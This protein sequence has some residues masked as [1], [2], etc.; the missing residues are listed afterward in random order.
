[1]IPY[2]W[3][4]AKGL[5]QYTHGGTVRKMSDFMK[6]S[7]SGDILDDDAMADMIQALAAS[8]TP[9][10]DRKAKPKAIKP[11]KTYDENEMVEHAQNL[12]KAEQSR[13]KRRKRA[14]LLTLEDTPAPRDNQLEELKK[15]VVE[16]QGLRTRDTTDPDFRDMVKTI[17]RE[18]RLEA[19][20]QLSLPSPAA[21][22]YAPA[23]YS[24]QPPQHSRRQMHPATHQPHYAA[25]PH[26]QQL[27]HAPPPLPPQQNHHYAQSNCYPSPMRYFSD[28]SP[29]HYGGHSTSPSLPHPTEYRVPATICHSRPA[30]IGHTHHDP[31]G[32]SHQ[33]YPSHPAPHTRHEYYPRDYY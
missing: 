9:K 1:M 14:E 22:A 30:H 17:S 15:Q 16:L 19:E 8:S 32:Y 5:H 7:H 13:K 6:F 12:N 10:P 31:G 3:S 33:G 21:H 18:E 2:L 20:Q 28:G 23:G 26:Q 11:I 29:A 27:M 4:K 24:V 25:P